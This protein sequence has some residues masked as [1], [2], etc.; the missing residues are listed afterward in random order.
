MKGRGLGR[1]RIRR[2]KT[3]AGKTVY[4]GDWKG[5]DGKRKR[6]QLSTDRRIAE[7]LLADIIRRRDLS[8]AGLNDE[9]GQ[10]RKL[11]E[12][13]KRY[14]LDLQV[15]CSASHVQRNRE[16]LNRIIGKLGATTVRELDPASVMDYLRR[17]VSAGVSNRTANLEMGALK[18]MLNWGLSAGLVGQNPISCVRPLPTG[19][20]H[21][22][23]HK[24]ALTSD[25]VSRLLRAARDS[26]EKLAAD[27][28][29]V[30]QLPLWMGLLETGGRWGEFTQT[31]WGDL[32]EQRQTIT[33]RAETTK[34]RRER[35]IP[36]RPVLLDELRKLRTLHAR[37]Y[38]RIPH[39]SDPIFLTPKGANWEGNRPN[40]Y[41]SLLRLLRAAE[42]PREDEQERRINI[43]ALRHTNGTLLALAGVGLIQT[44]K[45]LGHSDP[46]LTAGIYTHLSAEDLRSSINLL[47]EPE[48]EPL[49]GSKLA[50]ASGGEVISP[51]NSCSE[52]SAK[53]RVEGGSGEGI[54]TPDTR[55]MIPVL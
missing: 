15:R 46:K 26:D 47:P 51:V 17:R 19:K 45:L 6:K 36:I 35:V 27:S 22:K 10:E 1:G 7:R 34:A 30:P 39:T 40:A 8:L 42:I 52:H 4:T 32:N 12:L 49:D 16:C 41:R 13:Q 2:E 21:Q 53:Q 28:N 11:S 48:S 55:I 24:R 23:R 37:V 54:R 14:L 44:Q 38:G 18:A 20:A 29:Y 9:L 33:F 25:E 31:T 3:G 50:M 43:H 5:A